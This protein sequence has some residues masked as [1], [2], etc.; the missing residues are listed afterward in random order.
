[1]TIAQVQVDDAYW[2]FTQ[3]PPGPIARGA[4]AWI[5][6]AVSL[7][8]GR[9]ACRQ[10]RHQHRR[11][12]RARD[13][14]RRA[15]ADARRRQASSSQAL[16]G[17]FVGIVPVAIGLMFYPALRGVGRER[18]EFPAGADGRP[19][20]LPVRRHAR[21]GARTRRRGR[22]AVPGAG[23][24]GAG[25]RGELPAADGGRPPATARRPGWRSPPTSRSASACTISARGWPSARPSPRA[26][27]GWAPSWC[28]ASPCTTSPK[29]SASPRRS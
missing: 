20:R 25:G 1:M 19:A 11:D 9:G 24:G 15:D 7:G 18:H 3:D 28:S 2:Q 22:R 16:L 13:R 12:L 10:R 29:A 23:H 5:Q 21:G 14:G 6:P 8:A 4:T 17:V 27:P 26:R